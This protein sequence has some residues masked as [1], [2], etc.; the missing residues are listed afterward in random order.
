ME[1]RLA[2]PMAIEGPLQDRGYVYWRDRLGA[3]QVRFAGRGPSGDRRR[4]LESIAGEGLELAWARQVHSARALEATPGNCGEGDALVTGRPGLALCVAI[5]DCVPV[6]LASGDRLAAVHAGWRGLAAGVI[7]EAVAALGGAPERATAWLGPAIGPCCYEVGPQVAE[8]VAQAS[9]D[10]VVRRGRSSRPHLDLHRAAQIQLGA[11]GVRRSRA[12][13]LCTR[14]E[15]GL[16]WSFRREGQGAGRNL[17]Y[18]WR[19]PAAG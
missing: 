14:C 16:L 6:L 17:A 7:G 10:E 9:G 1:D 4:T 12:L 15:D 5:A 11:A 19:S 18:I 13:P 8:Q 3:V 2:I